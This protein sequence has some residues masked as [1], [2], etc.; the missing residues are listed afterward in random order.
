[1][2]N[3]LKILNE[4][5]KNYACRKRIEEIERYLERRLGQEL[6]IKYI[7]PLIE[8]QPA[9]KSLPHP[10]GGE[11]RNWSINPAAE[12]LDVYDLAQCILDSNKNNLA[13]QMTTYPRL[14]TRQNLDPF[15][16]YYMKPMIKGHEYKHFLAHSLPY[17]LSYIYGLK[18]YDRARLS[19]QKLSRYDIA[20]KIKAWLNYKYEPD[21]T[22]L[23]YIKDR[24][25]D[26]DEY[27]DAM[28]NEENIYYDCS[29]LEEELFDDYKMLIGE[30]DFD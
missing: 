28:E 20:Q 15:N 25:D 23:D 27:L 11:M 16:Y 14:G 7:K 13:V 26:Y 5:A 18:V 22:R 9:F 29:D 6:Q 30:M 2:A 21:Y 3:Y 17:N 8:E 1:M 10:L 4:V 12:M 24:V 19:N